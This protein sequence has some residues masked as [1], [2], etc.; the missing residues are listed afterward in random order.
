L[1]L[2]WSLSSKELPSHGF[3]IYLLLLMSSLYQ[4]SQPNGNNKALVAPGLWC[5]TPFGDA[6]T[7]KSCHA[8]F[9]VNWWKLL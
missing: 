2:T 6:N 5:Y 4:Q 9:L 8:V 3:L 7:I 1:L